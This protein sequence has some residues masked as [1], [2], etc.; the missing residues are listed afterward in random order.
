MHLTFWSQN[1]GLAQCAKTLSVPK[2]WSQPWQKGVAWKNRISTFP[3]WICKLYGEIRKWRTWKTAR[4]SDRP[5]KM[6]SAC[7]NPNFTL[8]QN[9][10]G[11]RG[12]CPA[13]RSLKNR[14]LWLMKKWRLNYPVGLSPLT[15]WECLPMEAKSMRDRL[16]LAY[17]H[18]LTFKVMQLHVWYATLSGM[19]VA[20]VTTMTVSG[21]DSVF[22][23]LS[24]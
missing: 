12:T 9:A 11:S 20:E 21:V 7:T 6:S 10:F 5:N 4:R 16:M 14:Q 18:Q 3:F 23:V 8:V 17:N 24:R 15:W 13:L 2:G 22:C 19:Y 1:R